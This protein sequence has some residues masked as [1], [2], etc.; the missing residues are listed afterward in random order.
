M[1][2][3]DILETV[4]YLTGPFLILLVFAISLLSPI[5]KEWNAPE[6]KFFMPLLAAGISLSLG[7][8]LA[9]RRFQK[10]IWSMPMALFFLFVSAPLSGSILLRLFFIPYEHLYGGH[11]LLIIGFSL[12]TLLFTIFSFFVYYLALSRKWLKKTLSVIFTLLMIFCS[13]TSAN[14]VKDYLANQI[15]IYEPGYFVNLIDIKH[16]EG[17][18]ILSSDDIIIIPEKSSGEVLAVNPQN[19]KVL[20]KENY[21]SEF[22]NINYLD[23]N[24]VLEGKFL[25][26]WPGLYIRVEAQEKSP[27]TVLVA[28][29][30]SGRVIQKLEIPFQREGDVILRETAFS[31]GHFFM[32]VIGADKPFTSV[33]I[34]FDINKNELR[35][36]IPN[37]GS[38]NTTSIIAEQEHLYLTYSDE[39]ICLSAQNGEVLWRKQEDYPSGVYTLSEG[40]VLLKG[41]G[42]TLLD[43]SGRALWT[44]S[45]KNSYVSDWAV[46]LP[47]VYAG[48]SDGTI[49]A[50]SVD[51]GELIWEG[52]L[53]EEYSHFIKLFCSRSPS[54]IYA[55]STRGALFLLNAE[56]GN[57]IWRYRGKELYYPLDLA[58]YNGQIYYL[59]GNYLYRL[60]FGR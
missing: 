52:E 43:P 44:W 47:F 28:D 45:K 46:S 60:S 31:N 49:A 50:L 38:S 58:D 13:F 57:K 2:K 53:K 56:T 6:N 30:S 5:L 20:W 11:W 12:Y 55:G 24:V 22:E 42:L 41:R 17:K 4:L 39:A 19:G 3:I 37:P 36:Q 26:L 29:A 21:G 1:K 10:G 23:L 54:Y 14:L 18:K 33:F 40:K 25:V 51:K 9:A 34:C 7:G 35:W 27:A 16:F 59:A 15:K 8:P 48:L 32:E